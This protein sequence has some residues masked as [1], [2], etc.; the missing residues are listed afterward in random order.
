MVTKLSQNLKA[1]EALIGSGLMV[2]NLLLAVAG[3]MYM[4]AEKYPA[5]RFGRLPGDILIERG[6]SKIYIPITSMLVFSLLLSLGFS[7]LRMFKR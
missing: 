2:G 3:L 1:V 7:L 6:E 5:F 4:L